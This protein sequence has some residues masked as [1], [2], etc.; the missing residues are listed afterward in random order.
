MGKFL[1]LVVGGVLASIALAHPVMPRQTV[2]TMS[3]VNSSSVADPASSNIDVTI[4]QFAL[5]V[6][7]YPSDVLQGILT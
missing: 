5:T 2:E 7:R 3:T 6:S 1:S 4:L